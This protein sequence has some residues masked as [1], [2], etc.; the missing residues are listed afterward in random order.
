MFRRR[1]SARR[2]RR[3]LSGRTTL[4]RFLRL[5][6]SDRERLLWEAYRRH[7]AGAFDEASRLYELAATLWPE[8]VDGAI[9]LSAC[10]KA[11]GDLAGAESACDRAL[12]IDP[13]YPYALANRAELRLLRGA[14]EA[15]AEDL[16]ALGRTK[17]PPELIA[18]VARL[19]GS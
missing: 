19:R 11:L 1:F 4:W 2:V 13:A 8:R 15:A 9:G 10:R 17:I 16:G 3:W 14:D 6:D 5:R 7:R 12:A 18:R